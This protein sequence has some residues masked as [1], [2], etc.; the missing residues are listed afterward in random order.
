MPASSSDRNPV[1]RLAEEFAE[2]LRNGESPSL[3]EY[4]ERY[5]Q[6]GDEIRE[7][8]PALALMEQLK[9]VSADL[10]GAYGGDPTEAPSARIERLGDYRILREIGRGGMGVV[11]EAEQISLARHVALKVLPGQALL[12]PTHLERFRRE[13]KAAAKLHHTNIVPVYGVGEADGVHFYAMQF[14]RGEGLD[15]ILNDLRRMRHEP[16]A[17]SQGSVAAGLLTGQFTSPIGPTLPD[18]PARPAPPEGPSSASLT[19]GP[20]HSEYHRSVARLGLQVAEALS[21]AHK[22]GVLHRDVKPS[23]LLLD[24][25]GTVWVTDFGLAKAE[26]TDELTQL[27]D[28]VGTVRFMAP[29]RFDGRSLP[30][31]DIYALGVTLYELLTLRPALDD[32]NKAKLIEKVLHRPPVPPRRI[33]PHLPRDL[34]TVILKCLAKD[35]HERYPTAEALAD[36]LRRFLADRPVKARR[37]GSVER[38]WRWCRRNPAVASLSALALLLLTAV[39]VIA[40]VSAVWLSGERDRVVGAKQELQDQFEKTKEEK[41]RAD[42]LERLTK[43]RLWE[44]KRSEA[45]ALRMSRQTGQRFASLRAIREAMQLPLPEGHSLDEL[46]TEAIAALCL[47]DCEVVKEWNGWPDDTSVLTVDPA[48]R[49]Y[50]RADGHGNISVRRIDDDTELFALPGAG[51]SGTDYT[52][53][54][55]S[56]DGRFLH[57]TSAPFGGGKFRGRL[58]KLDERHPTLVV[59]DDHIGCTFSPDSKRCAVGSSDGTIWVLECATGKALRHFATGWPGALGLQWSPHGTEVIVTNGSFWRLLDVESG[60]LS[61]DVKVPSSTWAAWHPGGRLVAVSNETEF[62]ITMFDAHTG[63]PSGPRMEGMRNPGIALNFNHAGDRLLSND[64]SG[65]R[66]LWDTRTGRQLMSMTAGGSCL[67]F[68][69]EDGL[70]AD[71]VAGRVRLH[72]MAAG[73][74]F[75]TLVHWAAGKAVKFVDFRWAVL[76]PDGRLLAAGADDGVVLIDLARSEEVGRLPPG[77]GH[78]PLAFEASGDALLTY[79]TPGL[80]RWPVRAS[81]AGGGLSVG[82]PT[83]LK[84]TTNEDTWGYCATDRTVAI[85]AYSAG[86]KVLRTDDKRTVSTGP[87]EDVRFCALSP[88]GRWLFTGTHGLTEGTGAKVWEADTGKHIADLPTA[89][90]CCGWF[91]PDGKWLVT[92]GG[93]Y[94][95]WEVGTWREG[96]SLGPLGFFTSCAFT[97]DSRLMALGGEPGVV[98]LIDPA[99]GREAARLTAP[100]PSRLIPYCFTPDGSKLVTGGVESRA[101][102]VFDLRAIRAGLREIGLDWSD[103]PLPPVQPKSEP[104]RVTVERP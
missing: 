37:A 88:D 40:S 6:H 84:S 35:P 17:V 50:A 52:G 3:A 75:T 4:L 65:M 15:R 62:T 39:A 91:S 89:G 29:E 57:F 73:G 99:T 2:R 77:P 10:T 32:S 79:G 86:A 68:S 26:G 97:A 36:D 25:Q 47:P 59:D 43:A 38:L 80:L 100:E 76:H 45:R 51:V 78:H 63:E 20:S 44:S 92:C 48:F 61:R 14:I 94:R 93:G 30:Q 102:H 7:L 60:R 98:R 58:W 9:P 33:D 55:F 46:R 104:L 101:I 103:E 8:F 54:R 19:G 66:R 87:Q 72:R 21:Y 74:E 49:R 69:P 82:S 70:M 27:G 23:N 83:H 1:D 5:P 22:Q 42:E 85:P 28:I 11:Y 71:V 96:P 67:Q 41:Q 53:L 90:V 64:W 13:A 18:P 34:E 16:S 31:S 12:N 56:P 24:A 81:G 95:I